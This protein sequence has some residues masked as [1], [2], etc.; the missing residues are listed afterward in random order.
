[1]ERTTL[2]T[3]ADGTVLTAHLNVGSEEKV[4]SRGLIQSSFLAPNQMVVSLDFMALKVRFIMATDATI[5]KIPQLV[6]LAV[7]TSNIE[8]IPRVRAHRNMA[9]HTW[10]TLEHDYQEWRSH[11]HGLVNR[12]YDERCEY[13]DS[14]FTSIKENSF[15]NIT[16]FEHI[17][18]WFVDEV[19]QA[20]TVGV[21]RSC[22]YSTSFPHACDFLLLS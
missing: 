13:G 11:P 20:L 14:T 12:R 6:H 22:L 18:F 21:S 7:R 3:L 8:P 16:S 15:E 10:D 5:T 9:T 1:M 19:G 2:P 4:T 17:L